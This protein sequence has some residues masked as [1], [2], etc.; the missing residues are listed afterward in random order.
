MQLCDSRLK[1][2]KR[3]CFIQPT[4]KKSICTKKAQRTKKLKDR[5]RDGGLLQNTKVQVLLLTEDVPRS[6]LAK[7]S[8]AMLVKG[9]LST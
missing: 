5:V 7:H 9:P 8:M 6:A 3:I 4:L 1:I 2:N